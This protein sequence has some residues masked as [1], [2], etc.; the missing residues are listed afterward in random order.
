MSALGAKSV[1]TQFKESLTEL[2]SEISAT[3]VQYIRCIKPNANKSSTEYSL[4]MV[5]NQL[6]CA[7]VIEAIRISRAAYPNRMLYTEFCEQFEI[8]LP[9][10]T[11]EASTSVSE[12]TVDKWAFEPD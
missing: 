4:E 12:A 5:V 10:V 7:G 9:R 1:G 2:M 11:E 6:R 3:N 8:I